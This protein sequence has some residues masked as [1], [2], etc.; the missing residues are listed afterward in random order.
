LS[1]RNGYFGQISL[2]FN[3]LRALFGPHF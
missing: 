3:G 1:D 2:F